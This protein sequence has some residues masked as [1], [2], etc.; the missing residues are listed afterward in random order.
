MLDNDG[1]H[2]VLFVPVSERRMPRMGYGIAP[3]S[4]M[5]TLA[6]SE[7]AAQ[8]G[9]RLTRMFRTA[10][11]QKSCALRQRSR[12]AV[13][14]IKMFAAGALLTLSA[15]TLAFAA[16][17]SSGHA[18]PDL[19]C[20]YDSPDDHACIPSRAAPGSTRMAIRM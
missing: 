3:L 20:I 16:R 19:D 2:L 18:A 10:R 13:C 12:I 9:A 17:L 6:Y 14:A 8:R 7:L 4:V 5:F 11:T 1:G 15:G